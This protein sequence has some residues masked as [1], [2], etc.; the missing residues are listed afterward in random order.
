MNATEPMKRVNRT[1]T[2]PICGKSDWCLVAVDGSAAICQRVEE[3]SVKHCGEAGFL[4]VLR[5]DF[6]W[7]IH[8]KVRRFRLDLHDK[9]RPDFEGMSSE[10]VSQINLTAL[11]DLADDLGLSVESMNRLRIGW[12]KQFGA[13]TFPMLDANECIRGIRLR[14]RLGKKWAIRGSRDGL[15]IPM[16]LDSS[17]QLLVCEGPTDTAALLDLHFGAVGRPSC[18]GGRKLLCELLQRLRPKGVVI[19]ADADEHG[20]GK[21]GAEA[22]ASVLVLYCPSVKI[23]YPHDGIKDARA[24]KQAGAT[25]QD[26]QSAIDAAEVRRMRSIRRVSK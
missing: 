8:P 23:I 10:F 26:I 18:M 5:D 24:W 12:A 21:R 16:G 25:Q 4:H 1:N 3:G 19:V 15:F 6:D 14:N 17:E 11:H 22:L 2:C 9:K 7:K 13:W 20:A